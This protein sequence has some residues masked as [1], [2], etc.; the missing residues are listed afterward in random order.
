MRVRRFETDEIL[1]MEILDQ[2][3][4]VA[5]NLRKRCRRLGRDHR[6]QRMAKLSAKGMAFG[7]KMKRD[8]V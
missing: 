4:R 7:M 1:M 2:C 3:C 6:P 5:T 8:A